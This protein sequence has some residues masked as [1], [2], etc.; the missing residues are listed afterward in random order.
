MMRNK[1]LFKISELL[2]L[3]TR[4]SKNKMLNVAAIKN[5]APG[6]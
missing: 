1:K 5:K 2:T 3:E 4:G 6:V